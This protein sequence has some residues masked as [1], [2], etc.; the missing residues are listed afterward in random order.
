MFLKQEKEIGN[1][2]FLKMSLKALK[3]DSLLSVTSGDNIVIL[4]SREIFCLAQINKALFYM[5]SNN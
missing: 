3:G 4:P 2:C 5:N 1:Y